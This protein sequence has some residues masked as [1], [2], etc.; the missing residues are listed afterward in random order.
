MRYFKKKYFSATAIVLIISLFV[1]LFL[2]TRGELFNEHDTN[3]IG[4]FIEWFGVLY[5]V[6]LALVVVEVW[7]K[8]SVLNKEI[9]READALVLL[10]KNVR[11]LKDKMKIKQI[12]QCVL[13]YANLILDTSKSYSFNNPQVAKKF[14]EIHNEVGDILKIDSCPLPLSIQII[15]HINEAID[16]RGD[17]IAHAKERMPVALRVLIF[18]TSIIWVLGFF[19][20]NIESDTLALMLCGTATFT[21]STILFIIIDL[22]D[23]KGGV[24]GAQFESFEV[25]KNEAEKILNELN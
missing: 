23:P 5:G 24:W 9:D 7:Q 8:F 12:G 6:L 1:W 3:I 16:I 21:V 11:F 20:L 10:L 22:D 25:L 4:N 2:L 17:W 18:L 14:D 19:G 13:E 15:Y